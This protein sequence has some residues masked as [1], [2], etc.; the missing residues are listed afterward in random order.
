MSCGFG[1][2]RD[3]GLAP[4]AMAA[5]PS[6]GEGM[7]VRVPVSGRLRDGL[8]DLVPGFE[9]TP[10]EGERAQ[11]LPPRLDEVE[12]GG[13]FRL[14][15]HLPARVRQQEQQH[16]GS[17]MAAQGVGNGVNALDLLRQP[18]LDLLQEGH[19]VGGAAARVG[20]GESSARRGTEGAEDVA[21]AAPAVVDLLPGP[22]RGWRLWPHQVSAQVALGAD[23][24]HLVEAD[25]YAARGRCGV[26]RPD[27]PLFAANSGSTRSPNPFEAVLRTLPTP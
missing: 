13:V 4:R 17:A 7:A 12:V 5:P 18:A 23:G 16:V 19:P 20:P 3:A 2:E 27:P 14:E 6:P 8:G 1:Q 9:A 26:E 21:L 24:A 11:H 22:A 10:G 25:N 15:H